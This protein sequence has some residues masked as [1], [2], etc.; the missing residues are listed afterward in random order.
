MLSVAGTTELR[1]HLLGVVRQIAVGNAAIKVK[2][3]GRRLLDR[4]G[5]LIATHRRGI[6]VAIADEALAIVVPFR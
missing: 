2:L 3:D 6:C 5:L 4:L 1:C